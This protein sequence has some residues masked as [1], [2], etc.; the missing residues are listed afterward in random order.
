MDDYDDSF[1]ARSKL[2]RTGITDLLNVDGIT[3]VAVNQPGVI[4]FE[5]GNGWESQISEQC[6]YGALADLAQALSVKNN[7]GGI[8]SQWLNGK[9]NGVNSIH[10]VTLPDG[11][12]GQII[13]PPVTEQGKISITIRKP[14]KSRFT[15]QSYIDSG[16]LSNYEICGKAFDKHRPLTHDQEEMLGLLRRGDT[17]RFFK[18]SV[19]MKLNHLMVG[20]TG[21]G[22]TTFMKAVADLFP[23]NRRYITMEDTHELDLPIH[24]NHVHLFFKREGQGVTAKDL[25]EA[26]MRMKP[27]HIYLT[28]LRGDETWNYL[29]AINTGHNGSLSSTHAEATPAGVFNRL[30][31]LVKQSPIGSTLD[32]SLISNTVAST[33]DLITFWEGSYMKKVYYNPEEKNDAINRLLG[34]AA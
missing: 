19:E 33:I 12:R 18:K 3:E 11:E 32:Y 24:H 9:V 13:L 30:T 22:K 7:T 5:R 16:R 6:N 15:L 10:S 31:T 26:A 23:L 4:W 25:I 34:M 29:G 28:E 21:S 17:D 1:L 14:S 2:K 27:D 20:A 8:D